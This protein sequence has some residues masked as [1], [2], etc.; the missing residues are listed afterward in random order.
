MQKNV[1]LNIYRITENGKG[2]QRL[3]DKKEICFRRDR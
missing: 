1:Q 3:F 2:S